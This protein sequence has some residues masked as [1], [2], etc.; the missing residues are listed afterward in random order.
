MGQQNNSSYKR[1]NVCLS[2]SQSAIRLQNGL[3]LYFSKTYP[4]SDLAALHCMEEIFKYQKG[5]F[6]F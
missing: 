1:M 5:Q 6:I 4:A 3:R 2:Y